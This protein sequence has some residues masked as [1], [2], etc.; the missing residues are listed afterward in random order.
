MR[1]RGESAEG[2]SLGAE[3]QEAAPVAKAEASKG[4]GKGKAMSK[5]AKVEMTAELPAAWK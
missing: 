1:R 5:K 3:Q 4:E 2:V